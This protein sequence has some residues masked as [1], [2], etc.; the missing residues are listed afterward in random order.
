MAI[1][2]AISSL[3]DSIHKTILW[4]MNNRGVFA[5]PNK[6][7]IMF[8]YDNLR[9]LVGPGADMLMEKTWEYIVK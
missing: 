3:G 1:D 4:H 7:D 9:E 8:H 5:D 6:M 2:D